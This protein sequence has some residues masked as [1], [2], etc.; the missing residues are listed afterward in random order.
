MR[1]GYVGLADGRDAPRLVRDLSASTVILDVEPLIAPWDSSQEALDQ[2]IARFVRQIRAVPSVRA[3]CFAT[4]SARLP[5]GMPELRGVQVGY[6]VSARKPLRTR[7]YADLPR[8]GVVIGDQV[9]TDGV[10]ARR[11]GFTFL[12]LHPQAGS[13]PVGPLLLFGCGKLLRPLLFRAE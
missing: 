4:N 13:M 9:A 8:P 7:P 3:V 6:L 2:G 10:L 1:T 11:L 5:S 12:H